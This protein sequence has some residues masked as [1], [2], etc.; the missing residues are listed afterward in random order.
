MMP[1]QKLGIEMPKKP[2][3]EPRLSAQEF[4]FAPAQTPSGMPTMSAISIDAI[5]SSMVAGSRSPIRLI[6]GS[7]YRK[8]MPRSPEAMLARKRPYWM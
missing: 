6:T 4:G 7:A 3:T 8:D 5:A 1:S 2:N